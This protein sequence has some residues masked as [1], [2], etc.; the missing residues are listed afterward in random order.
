MSSSRVA[1]ITGSA[2]GIGRGIALQLA[3]DGCSIVLNDISAQEEHL[4]KVADEIKLKGGGVT[5]FLADVTKEEDIKNLVEHA[6]SSFGGLDIASFTFLNYSK[7]IS[8]QIN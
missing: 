2:S 5:T 8:Y 6:V 3:E 4:N 1:I 7:E